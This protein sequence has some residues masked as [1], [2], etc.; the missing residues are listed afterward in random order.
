MPAEWS[1]PSSLDPVNVV[2][3]QFRVCLNETSPKQIPEYILM[4]LANRY[5]CILVFFIPQRELTAYIPDATQAGG[6]LAL[7][8]N[9]A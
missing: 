9:L 4:S 6:I 2:R 1:T 5:P 8:S 7:F 3:V